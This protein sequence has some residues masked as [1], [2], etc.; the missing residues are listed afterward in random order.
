MAEQQEQATLQPEERV[1]STLNRDGSRR[2]LHPRLSQGRYLHARKLVAWGLILLFIA[3]PW[4]SING[5]PAVLLDLPA[6]EF[7]FFG[8]TLLPTDTLLLMLLVASIF[9]GIFLMT[10]LLGRLW[11]GW[12]CPQTVYMEF[13]YRPIERFFDG[14]ASRRRRMGGTP[15]LRRAMKY[16]TYFIVSLFIAHIFLA[17]F[18]GVDALFDW[19]RASPFEH[20]KAFLLVMAVT[21]LMMFD[22]CFFREQTCIVAC[23]YGRLQ[24]VMLDR[25]S[26]IIS[27]DEKRG[28]PRGK[29]QRNKSTDLALPQLGDCI[30]C[31]M[32]VTTCPTG[33]DIRDGLQMECIG[34]A[35][36]ID[37]CD[38]VMTKIG[39]ATGLIRYSSQEAIET[40]RYHIFRPRVLIYPSILIV[41]L[42][43]FAYMFT[44]RPPADIRV[45][46][47]SGQPYV[48]RANGMIVND[49]QVKI[50]NRT[51]QSQTFTCSIVNAGDAFIEGD[52]PWTVEPGET[53]AFD[54]RVATP[55]EAFINGRASTE[56]LIS[57]E[58]GYE[59]ALRLRLQGPFRRSTKANT[60]VDL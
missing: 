6:R 25:Q 9:V 52:L 31:H 45:L 53:I 44:N 37:A 34:C 28:E 58:S 16:A 59:R 20:P 57:N 27:Y 22:F 10:A 60:G 49:L 41:L 26:L 32:C 54:A 55:P 4:I 17:Y 5:S 33:I 43:T 46:R 12:A 38:A 3:L 56:L 7:T 47:A 36:C 35:Q 29:I 24:S 51:D 1:L 30:N 48:T 18:V 15:G 14:K 50:V 21:G 42:T 8:V 11:C 39:R 13:V 19:M 40:G 23:P 2:W